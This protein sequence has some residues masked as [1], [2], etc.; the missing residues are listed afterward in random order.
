MRTVSADP[1]LAP[2][3]G[4][5]G[6]RQESALRALA[7]RIPR[8]LKSHRSVEGGIYGAYLRAKVARL[9]PLP[10]DARPWARQAG[11]LVLGLE[12]LQHE[13]DAAEAVLTNGA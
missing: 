5:A 11:L 4:P 6:R 7:G 8:A 13:V 9:G 3:A 2:A 12:R 10:G 1:R